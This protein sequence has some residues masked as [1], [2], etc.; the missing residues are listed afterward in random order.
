MLKLIYI[1]VDKQHKS[2]VEV[3]N[4]VDTISMTENGIKYYDSKMEMDRHITFDKL[5]SI[6]FKF[7]ISQGLRNKATNLRTLAKLN[8]KK[9]HG[10]I[11]TR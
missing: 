5:L 8:S 9:E 7:T 6:E 3:R 1:P 11:T 4:D 2:A 10:G